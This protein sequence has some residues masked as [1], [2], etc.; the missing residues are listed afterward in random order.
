[1]PVQSLQ[2]PHKEATEA[3]RDLLYIGEVERQAC[4]VNEA[5]GRA[6]IRAMQDATPT[7]DRAVWSDLQSALF[8][9]I[10]VQRLLLPAP[11]SVHKRPQLESKAKSQRYAE[12]RGK[13]LKELLEVPEQMAEGLFSVS[14]VRDPLEHIDERFDEVVLANAASVSDW[15]ITDDGMGAGPALEAKGDGHG[16]RAFYPLGGL[17][18]FSGKRLDLFRLDYAH[19]QLRKIGVPAAHATLDSRRQSD[20]G[21]YNTFSFRNVQ[22]MPEDQ[23]VSR[24][25]RWMQLRAE[26]DEGLGVALGERRASSQ[27]KT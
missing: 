22:F 14:A 1:M 7:D 6:W 26:Q 27:S 19:L 2:G 23:A 15:Y 3:L 18:Q 16:L 25:R 12:R 17:L 11:G 24:C 21:G 9:A 20:Q 4:I 13:R 10:I 5:I 8:A